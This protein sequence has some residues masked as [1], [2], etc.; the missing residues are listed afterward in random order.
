[1]EWLKYYR[2]K[3]TTAVHRKEIG[4][5][6]G[7]LEH[8]RGEAGSA[9]RKAYHGPPV[10]EENGIPACFEA[11]ERAQSCVTDILQ[12][13][14]GHNLFGFVRRY[15]KPLL[16]S[17]HMLHPH[18]DDGRHLG[19]AD[20]SLRRNVEHSNSDS[21]YKADD[22]QGRQCRTRSMLNVRQHTDWH[23]GE[24]G[25][26]Y[27]DL[28]L[29]VFGKVIA[30]ASRLR[31]QENDEFK[32]ESTTSFRDSVF[33]YLTS[34]AS[35]HTGDPD[36]GQLWSSHPGTGFLGT[37]YGLGETNPRKVC[38]V[39]GPDGNLTHRI[40]QHQ[41]P[42]VGKIPFKIIYFLFFSSLTLCCVA[43]QTSNFLHEH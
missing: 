33:V 14:S 10:Y 37:I 30:R 42:M 6:G 32:G 5:G 39:H 4:V 8:M 41:T 19:D 20:D 24:D 3:V 21:C 27:A 25:S 1:M 23:E 18:L 11:D 9:L 16:G 13:V 26:E 29:H 34:E 36:G 2:H 35:D 7:L 15:R 38:T 22:A 31:Q 17:M 40:V 43:S 28:E 12:L